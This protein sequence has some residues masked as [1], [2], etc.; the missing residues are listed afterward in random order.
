[1]KKLQYTIIGLCSFIA[2]FSCEKDENNLGVY[3]GG[4]KNLVGANI[5]DT[6][7]VITYSDL[8]DTIITDGQS[9]PQLGIYKSDEIG[10]AQSSL[11]ITF[12]P[13][14]LGIKFPTNDFVVDSL[15]LTLEITN[16]YGKPVNQ[17]FNVFRL[18]NQVI[19]DTTYYGTDT[20]NYSEFIGTI[21]INETDSNIY[22]F[23]LNKTFADKLILADS[24]DMSSNEHFRNF[25]KGIAIVP[26][27]NSL[28]SNEGAIYS[29][30]RT[31]VKMHL[32][33]HSTNPNPTE[34]FDTEV[35][36]E[37]EN[38]DYIF[39]NL[40]HNFTGSEAETILSDSVFGGTTFHTQGLN[41]CIG[42][43]EF[44]SLQAWYQDSNNYLINKFE[45]TIYVE[46]NST[47]NLPT[48]LMLTYKNSF[49]GISFTSA[50]LN[51]ADDS[52]SFTMSASEL[53]AQLKTGT[54]KD[55]DFTI[56]VPFPGSNP[57]QV[58]I[59]GG[60]SI[61]SPPNLEISYTTY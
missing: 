33:Y 35:I 42:K 22:A 41:G 26:K 8:E 39:A 36:Y 12:K 21:T 34:T 61:I 28:G 4:D 13:D 49:G 19:K 11:F 45:F 1:M 60:Q 27:N 46:D 58:K 56:L 18:D 31:G 57:N 52:Y 29:L 51:S 59:Y 25:F 44:P 48:E 2:F 20:N 43:V 14:T 16:V 17:E 7:K 10:L 24:I 40:K 55:M 47:F 54:A 3:V 30:S 32:Q 5:I 38:N 37:V 9:S 15:F 6:F 50:V 53:D 23:P